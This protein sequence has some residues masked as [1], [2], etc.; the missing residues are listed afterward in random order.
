MEVL[1]PLETKGGALQ[2]VWPSSSCY[3]C[4]PAN[5]H[6]YHI[7]SY[8]AADESAVVAT[9]Q[10]D[11]KYN[12]GFDN[13]MYGGLIAS[14]IDCHSVWTAIAYGYREEGRSHGSLPSITY[15]TG[16]LEVR[17]IKPTPLDRPVYLRAQVEKFEGRRATVVCHLGPE[18]DVTAEGHV[19]AVRI[20]ADKAV[21]ADMSNSGS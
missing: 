16:K 8:W 12:A 14:L 17:F 19:L 1:K 18:G 6:G 2:D 9:F 13:V 21:G 15:V 3:G 10:A 20:D 11:V 5:P 4:G 7:K